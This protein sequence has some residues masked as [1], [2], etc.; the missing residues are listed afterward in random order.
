MPIYENLTPYAVGELISWVHGEGELYTVV[1]KAT[2]DMVDEG[3]ELSAQQ[4]GIV[5]TPTFSG[6]P[7]TSSLVAESDLVPTKPRVDVVLAGALALPQ[8]VEQI[9]VTLAVG[10][11]I[12]KTVRVFG[13]RTWAPALLRVL[14]PTAPQPW[15]RMPIAWERSF[16]GTDPRDSSRIERRNPV[17][18]GMRG[19][20]A[21]AAGRPLPNFEDPARPVKSWDAKADPVGFGPIAPHWLP[22]AKLGGTFDEGWRRSRAPLLPTDFDA[23]F[24]NAAP[25]DQRLAKYVPGTKVRLDYMTARG[26]EAFLLPPFAVPVSWS[27]ARGR[28][29][30]EEIV[31]DTV[32]IYPE[33]RQ[34]CLAGRRSF[35]PR[36]DVTALRVL[37]GAGTRGR[38]RA[39]ATGKRY[40]S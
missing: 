8:A 28:V 17:G 38:L 37:V 15:R 13:D 25:A 18:A 20:Y 10:D 21:D 16:G 14:A 40:V 6:D 4:E 5:R 23:A 3:L 36:P 9:D 34:V 39:L 22:R 35:S 2:F 26:R 19:D 7:A 29:A 32:T 12:G 33:R 31:P 11:E 1:V 24:Y 30:C 27:D